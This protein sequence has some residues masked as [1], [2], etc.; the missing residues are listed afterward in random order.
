LTVTPA[1]FKQEPFRSM[2][3]DEW[4]WH[5]SEGVQGSV[6]PPWKE[7]LSTQERWDVIRY[8]Q[9]IFAQ[10]AMR[11]PAEG[12]PPGDYAHLENPVELTIETLD[13]GKAIFIR[14]CMVCHGDAG[15]GNGPYRLGLQPSPPDFGDGS[16]GDYTD[17]DYYWRIS[18]GLPWSA[19]PSWKLRYSEEDRWKLVHYIRAIFTQTEDPPPAPEAGHDFEYPDFYKEDMR[20][21]ETVSYE[22]G[23]TVF[24]LQC[25]HCHGLAGDG[26]GWDGT[27]LN[28]QPADF[29]GMAGKTMTPEAQGEHIAKVTFGIQD[30]AMP[31]WGEWLP[32]EQRWDAIQF[33][34]GSF[35]A[36]Q[37][38]TESVYSGE[39]P[40]DFI[41]LSQDNWTG[42]GHTIDLDQGQQ[43]YSQYCATCHGD[44]GQ[45]D[46]PGTEGNASGSPA[47]LPS[48]MEDA[49]VF[50]RIWDGVPE[51]VMPPFH[52]YNDISEADIWNMMAYTQQLVGAGSESGASAQPTDTPTPTASPAPADANA[53]ATSEPT[54]TPGEGGGGS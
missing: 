45:G 14:E 1:N 28:P 39:I 4:F 22:R 33:L 43:L 50:W 13:A 44:D 53:T 40:A 38:V 46:G 37:P 19:M 48:G 31:T 29:R 32:W 17:A 26:Q 30:T 9:A 41:T 24:L 51:S 20:F 23:K 54:D 15:R 47:P 49:Y 5:V 42:E 16:Y 25:A 52:L 27:Y 6:M 10:P 3:D 2:P 8:I 36:G 35:M 18:E 34:M 12:D 11:D 7:S 21:P